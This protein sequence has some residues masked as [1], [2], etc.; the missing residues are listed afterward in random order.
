MVTP[1]KTD[2][3]PLWKDY[4]Q[5]TKPRIIMSNLISAFGGFWLASQWEIDWVLLLYTLL[6]ST[7]VMASS[8]VFNNY[9]DRNLDQKMARTSNRPL[10]TGRLK[11][12]HVFIYGIILGLSGLLV[13]FG[14]N[15]LTGILGIIGIVV[16]VFIYTLWLKRTSTLSTFIGGVSGAVVPIIGYCAVSD[17]MDTGAWLLFTILVL[18]QPPHFWS[19]GIYR[20]EEYR[21]AGYPLLPVVKGVLRTKI[22]MIPYIVLLIGTSVLL[23]TYNYVGKYYLITAVVMGLIW[24]FMS[25]AGFKAKDDDVWAKKNFKFSINYLMITFVVMMIDTVGS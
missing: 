13:L 23:Y 20:K 19:L 14:I 16:Y 7:L 22:Q 4:I 1:D 9:L 5:L 11:P 15:V 24:L 17:R 25:L 12:S 3:R 18:W 10:P 21:A 2:H 6:G 8:C